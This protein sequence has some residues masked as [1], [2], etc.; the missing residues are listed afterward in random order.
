MAILQSCYCCCTSAKQLAIIAGIFTLG[1]SVVNILNFFVYFFPKCQDDEEDRFFNN[2]NS[3]SVQLFDSGGHDKVESTTSISSSRKCSG[4]EANQIIGSV[5]NPRGF[6]SSDLYYVNRVKLCCDI[7][8]LLSCVSLFYG[9]FRDKRP[10]LVPWIV[11][12]VTQVSTYLIEDIYL[13]RLNTTQFEPKTAFI[14]TAI[15]FLLLLQIYAILG[16]ISQYQ[17]YSSNSNNNSY[18]EYEMVQMTRSVGSQTLVQG[19]PPNPANGRNGVPRVSVTYA[20]D[21]DLQES[22][23]NLESDQIIEN[24]ENKKL[25][26]KSKKRKNKVNVTKKPLE[27]IEECSVECSSSNNTYSNSDYSDLKHDLSKQSLVSNNNTVASGSNPSSPSTLEVLC[28][29]SQRRRNLEEKVEVDETIGKSTMVVMANTSTDGNTAPFVNDSIVVVAK[30]CDYSE[31]RQIDNRSGRTLQHL[32][33]T[34][35]E[36]A[37]K[38]LHWKLD[39]S[40][41]SSNKPSSAELC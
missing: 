14:F 32:S 38:Y 17:E 40:G 13:L 28:Q 9:L 4:D 12:N 21:L 36:T 22:I 27:V 39:K 24:N 33:S 37:K 30:T 10:Y 19:V 16:V 6:H 1:W 2:Q 20:D 23:L 34:A 11:A 18:Q 15:F 41:S 7:A 29:R 25:G 8:V 5:I 3:S 31:Q 26:K 35:V